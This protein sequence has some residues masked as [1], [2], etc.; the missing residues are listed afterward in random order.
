MKYLVNLLFLLSISF[1]GAYAQFMAP[2]MINQDTSVYTSSFVAE[3]A[4]DTASLETYTIIGNH[5]FGKAIHLYPEPHLR[6]FEFYYNPDGSIRDMDI[7]FYDLNNTAIPLTTRSGFLPYR[8]KMN[9]RDEIVDFR[10]IDKEGEKQWVHKVPRMDFFGGWTPILGQWQWL[11]SLLTEGKLNDGLLFL[12][13]VIGDYDL[14]LVRKSDT[15]VIFKSAISAPITFYIDESGKIDSINA[16]GSPW[17]YKIYKASPIDIEDFT[18]IFAEKNVI[19]DPSPHDNFQTN[20]GQTRISVGY[21]RPSKRGREIF[22]EVVPYGEVWRTGAGP[23]TTFTTDQDL[24]FNGTI[25]PAGTYNLFTIPESSEWTLIFNTEEE[26][27]GSAYRSEF[28]LAKVP[29]QVSTV[30]RPVDRFT[31]AVNP[32]SEGGELVMMWDKTMVKVEFTVDE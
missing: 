26:A 16:I 11:T 14:E 19:G 5:M 23:P 15:E 12:N 6:Q 13:Y 10:S 25:I 18:S 30:T 27:W 4:G 17:N 20:I 9:A 32:T 29:M 1:S 28:D 2:R 8:I 3:W 24:N 7:Q 22:G 21:G 31:I